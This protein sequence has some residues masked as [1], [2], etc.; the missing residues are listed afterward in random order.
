LAQVPQIT[1]RLAP[2]L[3]STMVCQDGAASPYPTLLGCKSILSEP[4]KVANLSKAEEHEQRSS[5]SSAAGHASS[6]APKEQVKRRPS[7]EAA[8]ADGDEPEVEGSPERTQAAAED[9]AF[10]LAASKALEE[11]EL[12]EKVLAFLKK[13]GFADVSAPKN[14]WLFS[15]TY[16]LHRAVE[17]NDAAMVSALLKF[18]AEAHVRDSQGKTP[19]QLAKSQNFMGSHAEVLKVLKR[20]RK[21]GPG[22]ARKARLAAAAAAAK[23][24]AAA[25]PWAASLPEV[26]EVPECSVVPPIATTRLTADAAVQCNFETDMG[27]DEAAA[28]SDEATP[29]AA[30]EATTAAVEAC[31]EAASAADNAAD[32]PADE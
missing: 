31:E 19:R 22:S 25:A 13:N 11:R 8:A 2:L 27:A 26:P 32:K 18:N 28:P 23:T 6:A 4:E 7:S 16:P 24:E 5:P 29:A 3:S 20:D 15:F 14:G 1:R 10:W 12:R 9:E 21:P 30:D 17:Q